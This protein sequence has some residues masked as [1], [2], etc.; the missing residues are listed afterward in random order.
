MK[1]TLHVWR[2]N[3]PD[4]AG[5]HERYEAPDV[6]KHMSFLEM[7]DVVNERLTE[8]GREPIAFEHDCREG[9]F[10][11]GVQEEADRVHLSFSRRRLLRLLESSKRVEEHQ[12]FRSRCREWQE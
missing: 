8:A 5:R 10:I 7:L 6:S 9:I 3:G 4:D 12:R 11:G 1:L 2:Q